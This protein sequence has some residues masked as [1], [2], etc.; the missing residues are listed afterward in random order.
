[1]SAPAQL[2]SKAEPTLRWALAPSAVS[3]AAPGAQFPL[4]HAGDVERISDGL[5]YWDAWPLLTRN[6]SVFK[7]ADGCEFWFALA[8]PYDADID[9][10]HAVARIHLLRYDGRRFYPLGPAMPNGLSPGS[11]E[12]SGSAAIDPA[13]SAVRLL[14]TATGRRGEAS[15]TFEQRLFAASAR[16]EG[17]RLIAWSDPWEIMAADG[18]HYQRVDQAEGLP[19]QIKAL[20]DPELF[21]DRDNGQGF[22]VFTASSA[23]EPGSHDGVIGIARFDNGTATPLPPL[24]T[25]AGFNNELERPHIRR[26]GNRLYL[27]WSTQRYV[28]AP[29]HQSA[30]TGLYGAVAEHINGPWRLLNGDGL[31]TANPEVEPMQAYSWLVLPDGRVTSFVDLWGLAG[32][33]PDAALKR[34]QFGGTFSPFVML[35]IEGDTARI[36]QG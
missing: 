26:F 15:P 1:M 4:L 8:A 20:R 2:D 18:T 22:I 25:A 5:D 11:R 33:Q 31:V 6:G 36:A 24:V 9:A 21:F 14:F 35:T 19:G 3:K 29:G 12:W 30:P 23:Q 10:R 17:D 28:F 34:S 7:A 27:F 16:L 32:R 13:T